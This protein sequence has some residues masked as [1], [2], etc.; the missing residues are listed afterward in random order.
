MPSLS[1]R[2]RNNVKAGVFV[3]IALLLGIAVVMVLTDAI[4]Q[5]RRQTRRYTVI[6]DVASGVPNLK[7]GSD[8]RVGGLRMG[9][10]SAIEPRLAPDTRTLKEI[11]V[12]FNLDN[13]A[14]LFRDAQIFVS[15]PLIGS[16][17]WLDIPSV[18]DVAAG[19][20][21]EG[22]EI[23]GATSAGFLTT[24]LGSQNKDKAGE[25]IDNAVEFSDLL[26]RL[27]TEYESRVVP[28]IDDIKATTADMRSVAGNLKEERWPSWS[29]AIDE[30]VTWAGTVPQKIDAAIAEG[31]A[32]MTDGR[33][34][35]A[36]NREPIKTAVANVQ[37]VTQRI[38]DETVDK[39]HAL[40]D[41]GQEGLDSAL[42]TL[43]NIQVDYAGWTTDVGET[44]GNASIASQQLKLAMIE[45]RR[46][47]WKVLYRPS[48][49]ELQHELLY[50]AARSFAVAAADLKAASASVQRAIDSNSPEVLKDAESFKRIQQSLVE[51][52]ER[53]EKAQQRM[54]DVIIADQPK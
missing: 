37:D 41:Q 23:P 22:D 39:V 42:A 54:L 5:W 28:V 6:F 52:L 49:D 4:E 34:V 13:K 10:V 17:G 31:T 19:E 21:T 32:L 43:K 27:P 53:Y 48:A 25:I 51:S 44:L 50:E 30:I 18:G 2:Q 11:A 45:I 35:V 3:S 33:A 26:A 14:Q 9:E 7:R 8:V 15:A 1:E 24:L 46:S 40:L 47:P 12:R 29:A 16:E 36:E 38:K 20:A